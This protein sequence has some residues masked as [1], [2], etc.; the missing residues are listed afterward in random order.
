M[1]L[2]KALPVVMST[3]IMPGELN[4]FAGSGEGCCLGRGVLVHGKGWVTLFM[5]KDGLLWQRS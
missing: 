3:R 1:V 2:H 5:E 4:F